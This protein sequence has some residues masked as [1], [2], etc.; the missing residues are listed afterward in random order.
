MKRPPHSIRQATFEETAPP[1]LIAYTTIPT[2]YL[3]YGP[4][5]N[6]ATHADSLIA[7]DERTPWAVIGGMIAAAIVSVGAFA[8][9]TYARHVQR[10]QRASINDALRELDDHTL[11]DLGF[12]RSEITSIAAELT[13]AAE[14][15]RVRT[16]PAFAQSSAHAPDCVSAPAIPIP[17]IASAELTETATK[18]G[19][20]TSKQ[21][22]AAGLTAVAMTAITIGV[23]V[24]LPAT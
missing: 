7:E 3:P 14:P 1:W 21:R 9:E 23:L 22:I 4:A 8:R 11:R 2:G 13:G 20:M 12:H 24:V 18:Y 5:G 17:T 16:L 6:D 15:T 19:A 10:R